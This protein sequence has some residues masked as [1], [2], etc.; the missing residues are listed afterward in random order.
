MGTTKEAPSTPAKYLPPMLKK[1][2][3][4]VGPRLK[5]TSKYTKY[6]KGLQTTKSVSLSLSLSLDQNKP[7]SQHPTIRNG[8]WVDRKHFSI[9]F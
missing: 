2:V 8:W 4:K 6:T 9:W 3:M 5:K 1:R 7:A